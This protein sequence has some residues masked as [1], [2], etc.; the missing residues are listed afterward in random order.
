MLSPEKRMELFRQVRA[1]LVR[2]FID[3]GRLTINLGGT[4]VRLHGTLCRL[5][6]VEAKL[7]PEIVAAL[8][9]DIGR[10]PG[11]RNVQ[12]EFDNWRQMDALGEWR[13]VEGIA[14]RSSSPVIG[15][16]S[17]VFELD[18]PKPPSDMPQD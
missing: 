14:K 17:Q 9:A 6:G 8:M 12:A 10:V 13:P 5:P 11:V 7:I 15:D 2:H 18:G 3:I 4:G 16:A 1:V